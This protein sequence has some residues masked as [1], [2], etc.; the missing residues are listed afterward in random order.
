MPQKKPNLYTLL[1]LLRSATADEIRHA[2]LQSAKK[3]HPDKNVAPGETEL[4]LDVQ[5]AYQIL[6]DPQRRSAYDATL[7]E[8]KPEEVVPSQ[9][10]CKIDISRNIISSGNDKQLVYLLFN[11]SASDEEIKNATTPP[12]NIGLVLDCSTSM[13]GP[14]MDTA[15]AS[16]I[17]LMRRL[18]P[19]DIFSVV[20][21]SDRAEVTIPASRQANLH[22]AEM[23]I[24]MLQT[25]GGTEIFNGL[26]AALQEVRR[27]NSPNFINHVILLTD[28]KTYGDETL[29][30]EEAQRAVDEGIS[31]SG[32]GIGSG[33]NDVFLDHLANI[34][35]GN[36]MFVEQPQ[37][38]ERLLTEKFNR[39]SRAFAQNITLFIKEMPNAKIEYA[40][41]IQPDPGLLVIEDATRLGPILYDE[42]LTI[43]ME[44]SVFGERKD[45][46]DL[47]ILK[48]Y[49][50]ASV[51]SIM[52]PIP[53]IPVRLKIKVDDEAEPSP[54]PQAIVQALSKLTL[55]R[56]QE[57]ARI[58]VENG[59]YDKATQHLQQLATH[60]LSQGEK[61][62]ARTILLEAQQIEQKNS[63]SESGQKQIKYG[64]RSL[65]MPGE[66][67]S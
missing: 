43:I 33:W 18:R 53:A 1:G 15:K 54:P 39:L 11:L 50:E 12:L 59:D 62:L 66:R 29:C 61:S 51:A 42:A 3:L 60:L 19:Q 4:F 21:F 55:Y 36:T 63:F 41:R 20:S 25:G 31:I 38:I 27:Y 24:Q 48:G 56:I 44:L 58:A 45:E 37:D 7:P 16:A 17:Q 13:Q 40:F 9:I 23:Q 47:E 8:E 46:S 10:K 49:L 34:T 5:Q 2:Y 52:T 6:S 35:G 64:T 67:I 30:Y 26:S 14:K 22:R 32:L 65:L 28:G 57:K